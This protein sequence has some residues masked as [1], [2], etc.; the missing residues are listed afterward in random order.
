MKAIIYSNLQENL[1]EKLKENLFLD[2]PKFKHYIFV[3]N[4][5]GPNKFVK[6]WLMKSFCD[7]K[8]LKVSFDIKF[9]KFSNFLQTCLAQNNL[10]QT[11]LEQ[12]SLD[13]TNFEF[14]KEKRFLNFLELNLIIR[15]KIN[16]YI[17]KDPYKYPN[18]TNYLIKNNKILEKRFLKICDELTDSFLNY[19]IF[20][21]F[22]DLNDKRNLFWQADLFYDIFY[23]D[24][25][26]LAFRDL[27]NLDISGFDNCF[28]HFFSINYIPSV[29]FEFI[30]R[31]SN[32]FHYVNSPCR[33][34]WEDITSDYERHS[35]KKYWIKQKKPI[36]KIDELDSYLKERNNF[37]ANMEKVKKRYLSIINNYD[38]YYYFENFCEKQNKT[39]LSLFQNDI[40]NLENRYQNN[41]GI[42]SKIDSS[43]QI[44]VATNKFREVQILHANILEILSKDKDLDLSNIHV[45]APDINEYAPYIHMIFNDDQN[46]LNY[47][48][49]DLAFA[50]T[51][52]LISGIDKL[53]SL[54]KSQWEKSEI[55]DLFENPLFQKRNNFSNDELIIL[56]DLID[57]A[58]ISFGL[59]EEHISK[60]LENKISLESFN[61]KSLDKG[62]SRII[63]GMIFILNDEFSNKNFSYDFPVDQLDLSNCSL[64]IDKFIKVIFSILDNLKIMKENK[65]LSLRQWRFYFKKIIDEYFLI[66]DSLIEKSALDV[67]YN[68]FQYI[69]K[70]ELRFETQTY[71][72]ET[73]YNHFK[74]HINRSKTHFN[75]NSVQAIYFS[76]FD[77]STIPAKAIFIIGL[78]SNSI[79]FYTKNSMDINNSLDVPTENDLKRSLFLEAILC[80]K[81]YLILSYASSNNYKVDACN[82]LQ[83]LL[84]YLDNSY[85]IFNQKPSDCIIKKHLAVPFDK[86]YFTE[87]KAN[88][89]KINFL[90]AQC[91]Y[92]K[93]NKVTKDKISVNIKNPPDVIDINDLR[94]LSKN[95]IKFYMNKGLEIYLKAEKKDNQFSFSY[96]DKYII[97]SLSY[98]YDIEDVLLTYEK[99]AD[100][101]LGIFY[102]IE[103]EKILKEHKIFYENLNAL[104]IDKS[105]FI[106]LEFVL[107]LEKP[108]QLTKNYIQLPAIEIKAKNKDIK[109][110]GKLENITN[111]GLLISSDDSLQ[112]II[113]VWSDLLIYH[114][115]ESSFL[116]QIIFSKSMK[117]KS[118]NLTCVNNHLS[119]YIEYYSSCLNE[120]SFLIKPLI[121]H[122]LQKDEK[123]LDKTINDLYEDKKYSLD[124][125]TKWYLKNYKKP[126]AKEIIYKWSNQ[127][128]LMFNGVLEEI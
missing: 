44:H 121:E 1:L 52:H 89:S 26:T 90:A 116:K 11:S 13:Q 107:N 63:S 117:V 30:N 93:N 84:F 56:F 76:S 70:I 75:L 27:K 94:L 58:N 118:F 109:I 81:E 54:A 122:I 113:R 67:C 33:V 2:F 42:V 46:P 8:N 95:P 100:I 126:D 10:N 47:K 41:Y 79:K 64:I 3:P 105:N 82:I 96:L 9:I 34:F 32:V 65:T 83:E 48:I 37:L 71:F 40:L 5:F 68:F 57:R 80:A 51:S 14:F 72:F 92:T 4:W 77:I 28:F 62:L 6:N 101:P 38:D 60:N 12:T 24:N 111:K 127:L 66:D 74:K 36:Q 85:K 108:V 59:N 43:F 22:Q 114:N 55:I 20:G 39:F 31:F 124:I 128:E 17:M 106:T 120:P 25:Q 45:I 19:S 102:E 18:L 88:F 73:I 53:F 97:N 99:K 87:D 7:D 91:F 49:S 16:S 69:K 21:N 78:D 15:K 123:A 29:Y 112:S 86:E 98:K 104:G 125:Y 119:N 110:I 103:K 23:N 35:L 61:Q 50:N 115:L